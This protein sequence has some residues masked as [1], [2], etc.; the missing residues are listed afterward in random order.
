MTTR[1]N[2]IA[3]LVAALVA[4][5]CELVG[6]EIVAPVPSNTSLDAAT[7]DASSDSGAV[8]S[9]DAATPNDAGD[10]GPPVDSGVDAADMNGPMGPWQCPPTP[11]ATGVDLQSDVEIAALA[12]GFVAGYVAS[13]L[14]FKEFDGRFQETRSFQIAGAKAGRDNFEILS[15]GSSVY[16]LATIESTEA[17]LRK[18]SIGQCDNQVGWIDNVD[19]I[20]GDW[21]GGDF[22]PYVQV[23]DANS[24]STAAYNDPSFTNAAIR[25]PTSTVSSSV[26]GPRM[27]L[28]ETPDMPGFTV[29]TRGLFLSG[30][31]IFVYDRFRSSDPIEQQ[32][33]ECGLVLGDVRKAMIRRDM[34]TRI[35]ADTLNADADPVIV[36]TSCDGTSVPVSQPFLFLDDWAAVELGNTLYTFHV[37]NEGLGVSRYDGT[38]STHVIAPPPVFERVAAAVTSDSKLLVLTVDRTGTAAVRRFDTDGSCL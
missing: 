5:G 30:S 10:G 25:V 21:N 27:K 8:D 3:L 37:G 36:E 9:G 35:V 23:A 13:S 33:V 32:A 29:A 26:Y 18:C 16:Y 7:A 24:V 2:L 6:G 1:N 4:S 38:I 11:V 19:S 31:E 22:L 15:D 20:T 14:E 12:E 34:N 28:L 17:T